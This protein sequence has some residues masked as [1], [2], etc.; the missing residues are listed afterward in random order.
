VS[1]F[2]RVKAAYRSWAEHE[3]FASA[4]RYQ[5]VVMCPVSGVAALVLAAL[6][7]WL[8]ALVFAV[9]AV[10]MGNWLIKN[11]RPSDS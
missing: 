10:Y 2:R 6:G 3:R 9:A 7:A 5:F 1:G 8:P 4:A 11:R